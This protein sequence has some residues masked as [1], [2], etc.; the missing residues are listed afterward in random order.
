MEIMPGVHLVDNVAMPGPGG[1]TSVNVGLLIDGHTVTV[2]DAGPPGA[3][4]VICDYVRGTGHSLSE[5]RRIILTHHHVDH[6]GGLAGLVA[7]TGAEV[8]AHE[9]DAGFIDGSRPRPVVE[10]PEERIR[11]FMPNATGE[12]IAAIR[13]RMKEFMQAPPAR[14][15]LRLSGGEEL[16]VLDGCRI[17]HTPGHTPGH[18]CL[19]IPARSL[20][21]AGDLLRYEQGH[22][23]GPPPGYTQ[24]PEE[25]ADSVRKVAKIQ[26]EAMYG[27]HGQLLASGANALMKD[28]LAG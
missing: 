4:D 1:N 17:I 27:Y 24:N 20:M 15:D 9:G 6:T 14:V 22:I 11:A 26:F 16:M 10:M 8:W 12:E 2:I 13:D 5:I 25:A 7:L 19:H 21:I 18:I 23:A 3:Q 28:L